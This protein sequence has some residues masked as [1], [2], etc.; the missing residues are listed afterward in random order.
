LKLLPLKAPAGASIVLVLLCALM[1][2]SSCA[3]S[4]NYER[5]YPHMVANA[6]PVPAGIVEAEFD[7]VFSSKLNNAQ[8]EVIF[9]PRLNSVALEFRRE[10]LQY[11]QFWDE[12]ARQQFSEALEIYKEEYAAR[13]LID[14]HRKTRAVYGKVKGQVEWETFK[15]SRTRVAY[16]VIEL[17]YRFRSKMPFFV[18]F[19]PSMK[20]VTD[21]GDS[22]QEESQQISIFFTRAQADELVKLFD[23]SYLMALL[24]K[25]DITEP[26][27]DEAIPETSYREWGDS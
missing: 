1:G 17:G 3:G 27:S 18:S 25:P 4:I 15:Y 20:E 21:A 24:N 2:V 10:L 12:D 16:P 22:G 11:R 9:Y 7:R 26:E 14:Q 13:T 6:D 23:Q 5:K 19:M 8:I